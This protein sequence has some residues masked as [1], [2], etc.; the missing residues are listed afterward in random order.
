[1]LSVGNKRSAADVYLSEREVSM[2][3]VS[4]SLWRH[5]DG[6]LAACLAALV[7]RLRE[8]D[9]SRGLRIWL[10]AALCRPV[11]LAPI[12]GARTRSERLKLAELAA[13]TQSGLQAPC[14]V[15]IDGA[16]GSDDAVA[17]VVEERVL[18]AI[19]QALASV[20]SRAASIQP[21]WAQALGAALKSNPT[22]RALGVWEGRALTFMTGDGR[23]VASA[24]TLYPVE[25]AESASAAFARAL[26]SGM[27]SPDDA[28]AVALDWSSSPDASQGL[29]EDK[30]AVFTPWVRRLGAAS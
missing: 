29:Q 22:L 14:R 12:A 1:M 10:G 2:V 28:L 3:S 15:S 24:Q 20:K 21:W 26:V 6:A 7:D 18:S 4:G 19:E 16:G 25:T 27:I 9:G 17:V 11:R 30:G 23:H 5:E 8:D 13:V